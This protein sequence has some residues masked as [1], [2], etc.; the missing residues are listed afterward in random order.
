MSRIWQI[1]AAVGAAATAVL[2]ALYKVAS[3]QKE[4]AQAK[5]D[6]ETAKRKG[7]EAT[8]ETER[9][10]SEARNEARER[11]QE[12]EREN[13]ERRESGDRPDQFGDDRL[14]DD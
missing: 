8:Q 6:R 9:N 11:A 10:V 5:A 7:V 14:R 13:Q 3:A 1:L 12:V 2:F 4:K